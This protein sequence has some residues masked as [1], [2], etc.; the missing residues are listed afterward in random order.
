MGEE[1]VGVGVCSEED[2]LVVVC[3]LDGGDGAEG[4]K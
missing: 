4:L 3:E 1:D 2:G